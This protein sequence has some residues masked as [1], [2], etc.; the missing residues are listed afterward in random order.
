[1]SVRT[2]SPKKVQLIVGGLIIQGYAEDTFITAE[3]N[4]DA[5]TRS[6]GADGE[7]SRVHSP[8]RSG[9]IT[10]TLQ[11]T[12]QSNDALSALAAADDLS[13]QGTFPV[14]LKDN[15]GT[16]LATGQEAWIRKYANSEYAAEMSQRE[17]II[18]VANLIMFVGGNSD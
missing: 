17:W 14:L 12:S 15:N 16:T 2:Y 5:F 4:T 10:L 11:Q 8:D 3:R 1:M 9:M 7:T 18:D 6:T 13:L